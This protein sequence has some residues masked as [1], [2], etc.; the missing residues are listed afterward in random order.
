[1]KKEDS[2]ETEQFLK[3]I[4]LRLQA[5]EKGMSGLESRMLSLEKKAERSFLNKPD[6]PILFS[7]TLF[8]TLETIKEYEIRNNHGITA[9]NLAKIRKVVLPTVYEHLTK[10]EK[11]G[12]IFWQRGTDIGLKPKNSKFYSL[13]KRERYLSDLPVLMALPDE[14]I[15]LAQKILNTAK[16]GINREQL[17]S[18]ARNLSSEE[19]SPWS[20]IATEDIESTIDKSLQYLLQTVL[21]ERVRTQ[22]DDI[23]FPWDESVS[24][25]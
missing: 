4:V 6:D 19:R 18:Y 5:I 25:T 23:Y 16:K 12:H 8:E 15:P 17:V 7:K 14:I 11:A 1:M 20:Q 3:G 24:E 2:R 10:L 9:K 22:D 13:I 21:V